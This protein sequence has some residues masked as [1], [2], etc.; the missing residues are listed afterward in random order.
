M[1]TL[2][3][4]MQLPE[5][6]VLRE[7]LQRLIDL[8]SQCDYAERFADELPPEECPGIKSN[9]DWCHWCQARA[10]LAAIPQPIKD[11]AFAQA[12][13]ELFLAA[14]ESGLQQG[15]WKRDCGDDLHARN[16]RARN[17]VLSAHANAIAQAERA[18]ME[19]AAK[20]ADTIA[21]SWEPF[22]I[23]AKAA[24]HECAA[25]IR[26]AI[27]QP[28]V[29]EPAQSNAIAD[30]DA[31]LNLL[32]DLLRQHRCHAREMTVGQC[33]DEG[34]C[35]CSCGTSLTPSEMT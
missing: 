31:R 24:A 3:P 35:R 25:A 17:A 6:V 29:P 9:D 16:Q 11:E 26:A 8:D 7:A 15:L 20:I 33:A 1:T 19:R 32:S 14:F 23:L 12:L 10:A 27:S 34:L 13:E 18:G 21:P 4:G 5:A 22:H 2:S 30:K 28:V